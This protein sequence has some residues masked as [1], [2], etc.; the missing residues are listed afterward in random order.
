ML[1]MNRSYEVAVV[2]K[3]VVNFTGQRAYL[4]VTLDPESRALVWLAMSV[5][6]CG[7]S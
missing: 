5:K 4:W 6:S 3:T 1:D 7:L 2:D